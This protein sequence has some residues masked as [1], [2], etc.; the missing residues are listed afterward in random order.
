[1]RD[2]AFTP[3]FM[4]RGDEKLLEVRDFRQG[5]SL[6]N[7]HNWLSPV[8]A[9]IAYAQACEELMGLRVSDKAKALRELLL[10]LQ[11][12]TGL[13]Q[14]I[15][16][17]F[18]N[19]EWLRIRE[20]W[21]V[22]TEAITGARMHVSAIRLGGTTAMLDDDI[23]QQIAR[24]ASA[25]F[26]SCDTS[27]WQG[28]GELPASVI[29]EFG[30]TGIPA[31]THDAVA[32]IEYTIARA[33]EITL[34][35]PTLATTAFAMTGPTEASLPKVVRVPVGESYQSAHSATGR[36]G[37]WLFSDGGKSPYRLALRSPSAIHMSAI[38]SLSNTL[39]FENIHALLETVPLALGE[40][41]R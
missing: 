39:S 25:Q 16:G 8:A 19:I 21:V 3:G 7:R 22:I 24:A 29:E 5:L 6:I 35:L 28:L 36:V 40:I 9:E 38:A 15:A 37:V 14:R 30:M 4:H 18:D 26:P 10:E 32:R 1:M 20:E 13:L 23:V 33:R 31:E 17:T 34:R 41:D 11:E 27:R 12:L 2:G